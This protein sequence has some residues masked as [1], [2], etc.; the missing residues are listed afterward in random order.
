MPK[1][2]TRLRDGYALISDDEV[3]NTD[4]SPWKEEIRL[5]KRPEESQELRRSERSIRLKK[6][7][8]LEAAK[9]SGASVKS[10]G[11]VITKLLAG[12][13]LKHCTSCGN[14]IPYLGETS[15]DRGKQRRCKSCL[16]DGVSSLELRGG[17]FCRNCGMFHTI[18][19]LKSMGVSVPMGLNTWA[20]CCQDDPM[21]D[22]LLEIRIFQQ[23]VAA[24][25]DSH[26]TKKAAAIHR[27]RRIK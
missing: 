22:F 18:D 9:A 6:T 24:R 14:E 15:Q 10:V 26:L 5:F 1:I 12:Y 17:K 3:L 8:L 7:E 2:Q 27:N 25:V 13:F 23:R 19:E 20:T 4:P 11:L 21:A 16:R